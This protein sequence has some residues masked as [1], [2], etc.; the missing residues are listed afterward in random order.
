VE[1]E[2]AGHAMHSA[3]VDRLLREKDAW[4]LAPSTELEPELHP[5]KSPELAPSPVA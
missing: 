4:T 5:V 3:L 2:R 1:A